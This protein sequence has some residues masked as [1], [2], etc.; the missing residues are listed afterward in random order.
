MIVQI[1]TPHVLYV[2]LS[3][4]GAQLIPAKSFQKTIL[5]IS[6]G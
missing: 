1:L 3:V 6:W 5:T 2:G 4:L